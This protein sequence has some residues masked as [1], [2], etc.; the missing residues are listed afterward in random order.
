MASRSRGA[1]EIDPLAPEQDEI[2]IRFIPITCSAPLLYA[3]SQGLFERNGVRVNLRSAP[4]W[5]GIKQ[6]MVHG[7]VDM[8]HMLTPMPLAVSLGLDGKQAD[9]RL[10][11]IQNVNGD[12]LVLARKHEALREV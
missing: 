9:L 5:S 7:K 6:L 12:S 2:E 10:L 11:A 4:G 3:Q 8:A 1:L